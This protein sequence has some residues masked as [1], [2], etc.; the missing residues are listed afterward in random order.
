MLNASPPLPESRQVFLIVI[1]L[2]QC[3]SSS[4]EEIKASGQDMNF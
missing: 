2:F 4:A 3:F 1:T